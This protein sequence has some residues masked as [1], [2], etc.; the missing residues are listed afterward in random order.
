MSG[1]PL[2]VAC[3]LDE[4]RRGR[5]RE[6]D[7]TPV[8]PLLNTHSFTAS[9][10]FPDPSLR[11]RRMCANNASKKEEARYINAMHECR[12]HVFSFLFFLFFT[13]EAK[14]ESTGIPA[15]REGRQALGEWPRLQ[16]KTHKSN[17]C[18]QIVPDGQ[19][20]ASG[21]G[22][23]DQA[24]GEAMGRERSLRAADFWKGWGPLDAVITAAPKGVSS[25]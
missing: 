17:K 12:I 13:E 16:I 24:A 5:E 15:P 21:I 22:Y 20:P 11:C 25:A 18:V 10:L 4:R 1:D 3:Q 7:A 6:E 23:P 8:L 19:E 9:F 14:D 2:A